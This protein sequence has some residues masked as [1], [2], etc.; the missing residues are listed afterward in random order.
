MVA[1]RALDLKLLRDTWRLRGQAVAIA[2]VIVVGVATY[3]TM[4]SVMDTLEGTL[5]TYYAEYRFPDGFASAGARRS[6]W[7]S[8]CAGCRA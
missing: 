1:L 5:D 3:V 8:A 4:I 6:T 7:S 2:L